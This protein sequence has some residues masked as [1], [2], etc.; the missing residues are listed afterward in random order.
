MVLTDRVVG[1]YRCDA[2]HSR[3]EEVELMQRKKSKHKT[4][5]YLLF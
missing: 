1:D 4:N 2:R 3:K 5:C